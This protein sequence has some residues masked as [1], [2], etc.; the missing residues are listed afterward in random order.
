M[1]DAIPVTDP[2]IDAP[3]GA[4]LTFP[5]GDQYERVGGAWERT[6]ARCTGIPATWCPVHGD[7]TCPRR[8]DG[9]VEFSGL[10]GCPLHDV[11]SDHGGRDRS[12]RD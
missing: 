2:F 11:S 3:D 1:T 4:K 9:E 7:C 5:N 10:K 12:D 6:G 8:E